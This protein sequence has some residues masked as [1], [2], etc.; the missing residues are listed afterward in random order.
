VPNFDLAAPEERV[1]VEPRASGLIPLLAAAALFASLL[2]GPM[3]LASLVPD[4]ARGANFARWL[5]GDIG[6]WV[7]AAALA[8]TSLEWLAGRDWSQIAWRFGSLLLG[9]FAVA[10]F[11]AMPA[12]NQPSECFRLGGFL[13]SPLV[14]WKGFDLAWRLGGVPMAQ[15]VMGALAALGFLISFSFVREMA[16]QL[17]W[18]RRLAT[19]PKSGRLRRRKKEDSLDALLTESADKKK[20]QRFAERPRSSAE[21]EDDPPSDEDFENWD[22]PAAESAWTGARDW[23]DTFETEPKK[24]TSRREPVVKPRP[25]GFAPRSREEEEVGAAFDAVFGSDDKP[26]TARPRPALAKA[27]QPK[28]MQPRPMQPRP[29]TAAASAPPAKSV[30]PGPAAPAR[31]NSGSMVLPSRTSPPAPTPEDFQAKFLRELRESGDMPD[32]PAEFAAGLTQ[33]AAPEKPRSPRPLQPETP[34]PTISPIRGVLKAGGSVELPKT[35]SAGPVSATPKQPLPT[36]KPQPPATPPKPPLADLPRSGGPAV[37]KSSPSAAPSSPSLGGLSPLP[38]SNGP[39]R[40]VEPTKTPPALPP[41]SKKPAAPPPDVPP[42]MAPKSSPSAGSES[43]PSAAPSD[44]NLQRRESKRGSGWKSDP[45]VQGRESKR[46][47]G[48]KFLDAPK[49]SSASSGPDPADP[50]AEPQREPLETW[51]PA[52]WRS[53]YQSPPLDLLSPPERVFEPSPDDKL[54]ERAGKLQGILDDFG[55]AAEVAEVIEGPVATIFELELPRGVAFSRLAALETDLCAALRAPSLRVVPAPGKAAAGVELPT[56]PGGDVALRDLLGS[57][58]FHGDPAPMACALGAAMDGLPLFR[59]LTRLPNLLIAGAPNSGGSACLHALVASLLCRVSPEMAKLILIDSKRVELAVYEDIPHLAAPIAKTPAEGAA[60][61]A[62]L[63][64]LMDERAERLRTYRVR[65]IDRL[66]EIALGAARPPRGAPEPPSYSPRVVAVIAE[67]ADLS[68]PEGRAPEIEGALRELLLRGANVGIHLVAA[69]RRCL[70]E[71]GVAASLRALFP[72]RAAF[73]ASSRAES[74]AIIDCEGAERLRGQG[75]ALFLDPG[76][77][78]PIRMQAP[79]LPDGDIERLAE[80]LRERG[81]Q[82]WHLLKSFEPWMPKPETMPSPAERQ[83]SKAE[84]ERDDREE[85]LYMKALRVVLESG[86]PGPG[87]LVLG[88]GLE[89]A[90]AEKMLQRMERDG[91]LNKQGGEWRLLVDPRRALDMLNGLNGGATA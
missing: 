10:A 49:P 74:R 59:D 42:L 22:D 68:P 34:K 85:K 39:A 65:D 71:D 61:L 3:G 46:D 69:T 4:I 33:P 63:V 8:W 66:N 20:S 81:G 35:A 14:D 53:T 16:P 91:L 80:F 6:A 78:R 86:R 1:A 73:K 45:N 90:R 41:S 87:P 28:P 70:A 18:S 30:S 17:L 50:F 19:G 82:P 51:P 13:I 29:M 84:A 25:A 11:A 55:I 88:M 9:A 56:V 58:E 5:C 76:E 72:A 52:G 75:D 36:P 7:L 79:R 83:R 27:G 60:A 21:K 54:L 12:G 47:S 43:S 67:L 64:A 24:E 15:A 62:W 40:R 38:L 26:E 77:T 44:P 2:A 89:P 37:P 31:G 57:E 23:R 48:W 32:M